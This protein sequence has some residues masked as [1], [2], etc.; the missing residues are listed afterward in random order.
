MFAPLIDA[1]TAWTR[2]WKR[3][4]TRREVS[5]RSR[6]LTCRA[7][8]LADGPVPASG[9]ADELFFRSGLATLARPAR[10][11]RWARSA[12]RD[13][14]RARE[15]QACVPARDRYAARL[16]RRIRADG[17]AS[18]RDEAARAFL[19]FCFFWVV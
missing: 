8:S 12:P 3:T 10:S 1:P 18:R 19:L 7:V 16:R 15:R 17:T 5:R 13:A 2:Y 14:W 11:A 9:K 4:I 6:A